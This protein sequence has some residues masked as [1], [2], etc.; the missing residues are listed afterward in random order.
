MLKSERDQLI[1]TLIPEERQ[2]YRRIIEQIKAARRARGVNAREVVESLSGDYSPK[3]RGALAGVV[4]RD[5]MGPGVGQ[6]PPDFFLK[7]MGSDEKVRLSNFKGK[8]PV[9]L[10]Y[11]SYT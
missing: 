4:A 3:V 8:R 7:R 9:A 5:E 11:G 10:V 2:V 1:N 6:E